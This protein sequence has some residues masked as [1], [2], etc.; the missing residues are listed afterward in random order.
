[1]RPPEVEPTRPARPTGPIATG[2]AVAP[3]R[4]L[5]GAAVETC[6]GLRAAGGPA[7]LAGT[8]GAATR[9]AVLEADA[10][11]AGA[12]VALRAAPLRAGEEL[13]ILAYAGG[14]APADVTVTPGESG[15]AGR[16]VAPLQPGAAG[17]PVLDRSGALVGLVGPMPAAPR[18]VAGVVPPASHL[19]VAVEALAAELSSA[20]QP[21]GEREAMSAGAIAAKLRPFLVPIECVT[22]P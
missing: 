14:A 8:G 11:R 21:A 18:L 22:I 12:P 6:P 15:P 1:M 10:V 5:T 17:A 13:L 4:V 7:R 19:V 16:L 9:L 3:R 20:P 2:L